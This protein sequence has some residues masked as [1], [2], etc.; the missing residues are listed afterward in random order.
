MAMQSRWIG[1][2]V[3]VGLTASLSVIG[4]PSHPAH[5][6]YFGLERDRIRESSFLDEPAIAGA[7]LKYTWPELEPERDRYELAPLLADL[8]WLK[9]HGKRLFVQLQDVSF[10]D[11][12]VNVPA[13]LLADSAFHGGMARQYER[14]DDG[15]LVAEG[16]VARRWDPAVR[17]RF[18]RLITVVADTLDGRI[19]GI[20]FPETSIGLG[21][22]DLWPQGYTPAAY[23]AG[24]RD[25]M[26]AAGAAFH[27]SVVIQYANFMPGEELP[28]RDRS[29]GGRTGP[30]AAPLVPAAQQLPAH[31]GPR[32]RRR[33]GARGAVGEPGRSRSAHRCAGHSASPVRV[34]RGYP[35]PGLHLLGNAAAVLQPGHLAVPTRARGG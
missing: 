8:A 2:G 33:C 23:A 18:V 13:Y 25:I 22:G 32:R 1:Y 11:T 3:A 21:P 12:I 30:A 20:N 6:I 27:R 19:E 9:R 10:S 7:Q 29:R 17:A 35:A 34:R 5:Y 24:I 26:T 28:D 31:R 15:R 16:W 14:A 4:R